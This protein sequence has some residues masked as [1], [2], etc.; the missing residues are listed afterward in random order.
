MGA[1]V[2][3]ISDAASSVGNA[4]TSV[5]KSV[6]KAVESVGKF[7]GQV[8][9][10]AID[11]PLETLAT[12]AVIALAPY[13]APL[14]GASIATTTAIG[15][16]LVSATSVIAN[17][18]SVGEALKA[19]ALSAGTSWLGASVGAYVGGEVG[20]K[21]VGD[22]AGRAV[23][24]AGNAALTGRDVLEGAGAGALQGL[25]GNLT[26]SAI[27][28]IGLTN[29]LTGALGV[30]AGTYAANAISSGLSGG[31]NALSR[32]Q[33]F[34]VGAEKGIATSLF[35]S[36]LGTIATGARD[37]AKETWNK[38]IAP[39]LTDIG[40]LRSDLQ[41]Q[42][43]QIDAGVTQ[44]NDYSSQYDTE[45][46][47]AQD[48]A[49]EATDFAPG[50][51]TAV[52]DI[53]RLGQVYTDT[54]AAYDEQEA[55]TR[56]AYDA[57]QTKSSEYD[58]LYQQYQD[59]VAANNVD[60][61][62]RLAGI[63][64]PMNDELVQL[65]TS[66]GAEQDKLNTLV[67]ALNTATD[68]VN[69][70]IAD[71]QSI[72]D[73]GTS[74]NE[75]LSS[76]RTILQD[77]Q[78]KATELQN[79]L[80]AQRDTYDQG[81]ADYTARNDELSNQVQAYD[82]FVEAFKSGDTET[83]QEY[84]RRVS[85]QDHSIASQRGAQA[86]A[87][88]P[89]IAQAGLGV[90]QFDDG[91]S[92]QFFDDGS[93]IVTDSE[94]QQ[95]AYNEQGQAYNADAGLIGA[96]EQI[97]PGKFKQTFDD[98]SYIITDGSG[99]VAETYD[100]EGQLYEPGSNPNL[101]ANQQTKQPKS[102]IRTN[103][104]IGNTAAGKQNTAIRQSTRTRQQAT[105]DARQKAIIQAQQ[106]YGALEDTVNGART[107]QTGTQAG[108]SSSGQADNTATYSLSDLYKGVGTTAPLTALKGVS[109]LE[110][111]QYTSL[112]PL[113][114]NYVADKD[115]GITVGDTNKSETDPFKVNIDPLT[116]LYAQQTAGGSNF[117]AQ[118][119]NAALSLTNFN[120]D[121][122]SSLY[123]PHAAGGGVIKRGPRL[124]GGAP[125]YGASR[126]AVSG[127]G[128]GVSD[129]IRAMVKPQSYVIPARAVS[130]IGNGSSSAG[131]QKLVKFTHH[132]GS[133][134][135]LKHLASGGVV[136]QNPI[137]AMLSQDEF[138]I[139]PE[140]VAHIGGGNVDV[141]ARKLDG[142]V[143]QIDRRRKGLG[144]IADDGGDYLAGLT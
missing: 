86:E 90:Q 21:L 60:E 95:F 114:Q 113:S 81:T 36:T 119:P 139:P 69:T 122:L 132:I 76:S 7:V 77:I 121:P 43:K 110:G 27:K 45:Y 135:A 103:F 109:N 117:G 85:P 31:L 4:I 3:A 116:S 18:G 115:N 79:Q 6:G 102:A 2:Q 123:G 84:L 88:S 131:T 106:R 26:G 49:K 91:S 65:D 72:L 112:D 140:V 55:L 130:E 64:N 9:Q 25:V 13:A 44:L 22:V 67:T 73:K 10:H 33:D 100:T 75:A 62:N 41:D 30:G 32:G 34:T 8:V 71:N 120:I 42:G 1:V 20:S 52:E 142:M 104:S 78:T 47:K 51:Q 128:D 11:N 57:Y 125:V 70:S 144:T 14:I 134:G 40:N 46:R 99:N 61:A 141:G 87:E 15:M 98:G 89:W 93:S 124:G 54:K 59:A 133:L 74:Y 66:F 143:Q 96:P 48:L 63:L 29:T 136:D 138:V 105:D 82:K 127:G 126:T 83:A 101:P 35:N 129:S 5:V 137:E 28:E 118:D 58:G 92:I 17:G 37:Y 80:Q 16:G 108:T 50:Y 111:Q 23:A 53:R 24:G 38:N 56:Q 94:G 107:S 68:N 12:I 39:L 19:A 97:G